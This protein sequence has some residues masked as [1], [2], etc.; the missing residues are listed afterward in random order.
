MSR[1][2]TTAIYTAVVGAL[3]VSAAAASATLTLTTP[4]DNQVVREN[5][6]IGIPVSALPAGFTIPK[7]DSSP[8]RTGRSCPY[9]WEMGCASSWWLL[10]LQTWALSRMQRVFLLEQQVPYRDPAEP[11]K[12][13][14]FKDGKYTLKVQLYAFGKLADT[15][16][17]ISSSRT[18]SREGT[19]PRQSGW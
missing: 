17:S 13:K 9:W 19:R 15:L 11:D 5:V 3:L 7:G 6:K 8:L 10:F 12:D 18:R 16:Q 14:F 2:C 1:F 4:T